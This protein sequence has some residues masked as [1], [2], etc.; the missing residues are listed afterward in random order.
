LTVLSPHDFAL[1]P[2]NKEEKHVGGAA[3]N[4]GAEM[5]DKSILGIQVGTESDGSEGRFFFYE[6]TFNASHFNVMELLCPC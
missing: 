4:P 2:Q 5:E 3:K 1:K 6:T